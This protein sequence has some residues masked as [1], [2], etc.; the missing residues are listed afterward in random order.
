MNTV[1]ITNTMVLV[2]LTEHLK[3][4]ETPQYND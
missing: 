3:Q 2:S 4:G 1:K